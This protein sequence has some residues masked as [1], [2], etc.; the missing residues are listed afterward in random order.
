MAWFP[1]WYKENLH[2]HP[3]KSL[4]SLSCSNMFQWLSMICLVAIIKKSQRKDW[5]KSCCFL[6]H[7]I[8]RAD[9]KLLRNL[10]LTL[11]TN[12]S[13]NNS[14][15]SSSSRNAHVDGSH[16]HF[17]YLSLYI[18]FT[19]NR[20]GSQTL[21]SNLCRM[22]Q[23]IMVHLNYL[24]YLNWKKN[25]CKA[26]LCSC[27]SQDFESNDSFDSSC[28]HLQGQ[29]YYVRVSAYN[30]RGWGPPCKSTPEYASPSSRWGW[31]GLQ[32]V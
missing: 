17:C 14:F 29:R 32:F 15:S 11:M 16:S 27:Y 31:S 13:N 4:Q 25:L 12:T 6:D 20:I 22:F 23:L 1:Q 9:Q 28:F 3:W 30:M 21:S 10:G 2:H 5:S 18:Y 8:I 26:L 24:N 19:P 7:G